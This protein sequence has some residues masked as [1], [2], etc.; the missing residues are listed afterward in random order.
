MKSGM[1]YERS[2]ERDVDG[3]KRPVGRIEAALMFIREDS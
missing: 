2:V 3:E 1:S